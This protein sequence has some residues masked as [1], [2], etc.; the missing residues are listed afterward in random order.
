LTGFSE[1]LDFLHMM[2]IAGE[3]SNADKGGSSLA[4]II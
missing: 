4:E 3:A 2:L 1:L